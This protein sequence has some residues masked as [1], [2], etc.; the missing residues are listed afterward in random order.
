MAHSGRATAL[1]ELN[2]HADAVADWDKALELDDGKMRAAYQ[3]QR[4]ICV[5]AA[6]VRREPAPPPR[7]GKASP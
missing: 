7:P 4:A 1:M 2:R 6:N 3:Q 5:Q